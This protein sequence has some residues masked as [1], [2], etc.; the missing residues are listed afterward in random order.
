VIDRL[1][2]VVGLCVDLHEKF[3][4]MPLPVRIRPQLLHPF[5]PDL[6]SKHRAKSVPP[7]SNR[8]IADVD[9]GFVQKILHIAKRK[10]ETNIHHN[11]QTD[12][13]GARLEIAKWAT[14]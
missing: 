7:K 6:G 10:R 13:L 11:S 4:Q 5:P 8:L 14:F 12:D 9:A 1:P 3:V 2:K